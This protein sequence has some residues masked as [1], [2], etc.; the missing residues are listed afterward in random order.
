MFLRN[1]GLIS[2]D[3]MA[4]YPRIQGSSQPPLW[5]PQILHYFYSLFTIQH[6]PW[7]RSCRRE[8]L[9]IIFS[10]RKPD[11]VGCLPPASASFLLG[12]L[13]DPEDRSNIFL[14]NVR[15]SPNY[16]ALQI[17]ILYSSKL[18]QSHLAAYYQTQ[19][20]NSAVRKLGSALTH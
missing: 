19:I 2:T 14:W 16:R 11:N 7:C 18:E 1:V 10:R 12:L 20:A 5:E 8:V 6:I 17:E 13:S 15:F 4:L 9:Q 3:Y